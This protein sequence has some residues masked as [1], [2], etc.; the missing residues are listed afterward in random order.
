MRKKWSSQAF[1]EIA[2]EKFFCRVDGDR[3][4]FP[5]G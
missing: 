5:D 4:L 2:V 3:E 1:V